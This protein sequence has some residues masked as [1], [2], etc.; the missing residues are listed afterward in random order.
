M[1]TARFESSWGHCK[2]QRSHLS[3]RSSLPPSS[4]AGSDAGSSPRLRKWSGK[5]DDRLQQ[6]VSRCDAGIPWRKL[7]MAW[8]FGVFRKGR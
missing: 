7:V 4:E 1:A 2:R 8:G 3:R 6:D 5:R